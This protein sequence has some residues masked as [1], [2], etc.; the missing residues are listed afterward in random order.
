MVYCDKY[1][2][3]SE[4]VQTS[5]DSKRYAA[6]RKEARA[7]IAKRNG[8]QAPQLTESADTEFVKFDTTEALLEALRKGE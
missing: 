8:Q 5:M 2:I 3:T 4:S 7:R 6:I 1:T